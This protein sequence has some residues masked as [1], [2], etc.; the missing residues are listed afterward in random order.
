MVEIRLGTGQE[1]RQTEAFADG[2]FAVRS[3][4]ALN[5]SEEALL[6]ALPRGKTGAALAVNSVEGLAGMALRAL[7]P[8]LAVHCHFDDAWD[9]AAAQAAATQNRRLTPALAVAPDPPEGPWDIIALPFSAAGVKDLLLERLAFAVE[10]LK[11]GGLLFASTDNRRDRFLREEV[12]KLFGAATTLPGP[13]RRSGVAYIA[14]RPKSPRLRERPRERAFTV[15][16]GDRVLPLVSRPGVFSHGRLD[17][18]TRALLASADMGVA[19]R[20]LDLGCGA[21]ILGIVAALR[22]PDARVTLVDS[23]ARAI[24]CAQRNVESLGLAGRCEAVLTADPLRGLEAGYDLVLTNPPYYGNYRISEMFLAAAAKVLVPGGRMALVTKGIEWH[25]AA[26]AKLFGSVAAKESGGYW[27]L[28][29]VAG[30]KHQGSCS[31]DR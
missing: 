2:A 30:G 9:L 16:E 11:P 1:R 26:M 18:G 28:T 27:V 25:K 15:K 8:D 12:V 14:R 29:A 20:V 23:Y 4:K 17:E 6:N 24:Q 7:S 21:G 19:K 31:P 22:S 10:H 13:S 5:P 3:P